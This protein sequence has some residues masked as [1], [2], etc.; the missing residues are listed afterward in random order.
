MANHDPWR[1]WPWRSARA[2]ITGLSSA[3]AAALTRLGDTAPSRSRPATASTSTA[4]AGA[5][6][7][8]AALG[9]LD[10]GLGRSLTHD[11]RRR[12]KVAPAAPSAAGQPLRWPSDGAYRTMQAP[13]VRRAP[14]Q[15]GAI[16][17]STRPEDSVPEIRPFRA[18]RY[19]PETV[20]DA[21][22]VVAPPYDVIGADLHRRLLARHPRNAVRLDLPA[23]EPGE[24]PDERYRR[25]ARTLTAWR[26]DG[27]LRK[28]PRPS[29]YVY[30]QVYRGAGHGHRADAA[31]VLCPA[32]HR[33]VRARE[34]GAP[35][36][37][38]AVG[39]QG[40]PLPAAAG[41]GHQHSPVVGLY[42]DVGNGGW[43]LLAAIT[44]DRPDHGRRRTMT[45]FTTACGSSP[46]RARDHRPT[47][48]SRPPQ[49]VPSSSPTAT[50]A[51]RPRSATGTSG[52]R[53]PRSRTRR[54]TSCS[55]SSSTP[56]TG[57]PSCRRTAS[58]AGWATRDRRRW[59]ASPGAVRHDRR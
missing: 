44:A 11:A 30:Q 47:R 1:T 33:A 35:A 41:H 50:T 45:G 54:S 3:L 53:P 21:A 43:R 40:G 17:P 4:R 16:G 58:C 57:S 7:G 28:D 13:Q 23:G 36:R 34:L 24:D 10:L 18:L 48:S 15:R 22:R 52:A 59:S 31:R 46:M 5:G 38:D 26:S 19:D 56:R 51:T 55:C 27:T 2:A 49:R 20:G 12:R 29:V 8:A 6:C 42:E 39:S 9:L 25:A 37:A 32:A 14:P